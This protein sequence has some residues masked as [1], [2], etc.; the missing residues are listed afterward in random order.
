MA[1]VSPV[2][3][4]LERIP[5]TTWVAA[6]A[7]ALVAFLAG[8]AFTRGVVKQLFTMASLA[9][10]VA[11][12]WYVFRHRADVFGR[13]STS[14]TTDRLLIFSAAAGVLTFILCKGAV[15]ILAG[16]GLL[17]LFGSL[18]GWKGMLVSVL[19]SGFLLW[20]GSMVLRLV[21][22]LYGLETASAVAREGHRLT[23][24]ASTLWHQVSQK[25]DQSS[26]GSL[27]E[28]MDPFDMRATANLARLLILW[29]DGTEWARLAQ[30]PRTRRLL[31][32]PEI[33]RLGRDPQVRRCIDQRD[34]AG[35]MQL[36]QVENT[37]QHADLRPVLNGLDLEQAMD[38]IIYGKQGAYRKQGTYRPMRP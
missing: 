3:D 25:V 31:N 30:D 38:R 4:T 6:S 22:N 10:A 15:H 26:L 23:S 33:Q 8:L 37:A 35:L 5:L 18:N 13:G 28:R 12:A 9:I 14:M 2:L 29:P 20:V 16:L 7:A 1:A 34:F 19:P 24:E 27:A 17:R 36:P 32:H 21:G 11:V